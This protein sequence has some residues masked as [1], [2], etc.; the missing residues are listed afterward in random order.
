M[1][2]GFPVKDTFVNGDVYNASD[3]NDLAG[4]VNLVPTIPHP[5]L[6]MGA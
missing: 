3:V 2:V 4:T 6:V 5:F 1:A